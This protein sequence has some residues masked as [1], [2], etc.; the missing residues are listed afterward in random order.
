MLT[1]TVKGKQQIF[2][3]WR[4]KFVR[5]TPE[6]W[7]RQQIL[8]RLVDEYGYP[9]ALIAVEKSI[10]VGS[11]CKRCDAVVYTPSLMPLVLIEFKADTVPITQRVLDQAV[12]YNRALHVPYLILSNGRE[13]LSTLIGDDGSTITFLESIP[14][15]NQLSR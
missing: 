8:H 9:A 7:V 13:S 12:I 5:L 11:V 6:E 2:C 14:T 3:D 15:W 10:R 4:R 1:R